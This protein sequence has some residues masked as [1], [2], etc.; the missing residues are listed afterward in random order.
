M[1]NGIKGANIIEFFLGKSLNFG[2][3]KTTELNETL[4]I[5]KTN[6]IRLPLI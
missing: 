6:G 2:Q 5:T 4:I 1:F 3:I